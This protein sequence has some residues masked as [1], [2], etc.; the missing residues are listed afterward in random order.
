MPKRTR[1]ILYGALFI[2]AIQFLQPDR[3]NP[4][5]DERR[6][7][8][9]HLEVPPDVEA[10]LR[11]ACYS[12]HSDETRWPWYS[13]IAPFAWVVADDIHRGRFEMNLSNWARH[14]RDEAAQRLH[15]SCQLAR[16]GHMPPG[17]YQWLNPASRLSQEEVERLCSWADEQRRKL[18]EQGGPG[19]PGKS[20]RCLG[21]GSSK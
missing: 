18:L 14:D 20:G 8:Q 11:R 9:A 17:R 12:C 6:T 19:T 1:W 13:R 3:S 5:V 7:V 10:I 2:I 16:E 15:E 4:P 21:E